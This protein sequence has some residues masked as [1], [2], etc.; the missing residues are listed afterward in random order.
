MN[1]IYQHIIHKTPHKSWKNANPGLFLVND[2]GCILAEIRAVDEH[3][4][5]WITNEPVK[6]AKISLSD[7]ELFAKVLQILE[8]IE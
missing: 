8:G 1:P 2:K 3:L 5:V 4:A 6:N 7:P